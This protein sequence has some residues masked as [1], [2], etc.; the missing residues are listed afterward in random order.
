M[1]ETPGI[2]ERLSALL[3]GDLSEAEIAALEAEFGSADE[4]AAE[5]ASMEA[6]LGDLS[7]LGGAQAPV[8]LADR[9]LAAVAEEPLVAANSPASNVVSMASW[10]RIVPFAAAALVLLSLGV[11]STRGEPDPNVPPA[12]AQLRPAADVAPSPTGSVA[13]DGLADAGDELSA[14]RDRL[15]SEAAERDDLATGRELLGAPP[16]EVAV[17]QVPASPRRSR[18]AP[19]PEPEPE[20]VFVAEFEQGSDGV[21]DGGDAPAAD[22]DLG[23]PSADEAEEAPRPAARSRA[24]APAIASGFAPEGETK[25]EEVSFHANEGAAR[26]MLALPDGDAVRRLEAGI[27]S[28]GWRLQRSGNTPDKAAGEAQWL[29]DAPAS[30]ADELA[31]ALQGAGRYVAGGPPAIS[32][33]RA[34][35]SLRVRWGN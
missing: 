2:D 32:N 23:D 16:T 22:A 18:P 28:R 11:L 13:S 3:D 19:K 7:S 35:L 25:L 20:G 8:G 29:I 34:R 14:L 31:R 17:G 12:L 30:D 24:A 33:G 9:V 10:R 15:E 21:A 4:L 26:G 6:M 27:K 1:D 5:R